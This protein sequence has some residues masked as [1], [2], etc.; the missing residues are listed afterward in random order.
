MSTNNSSLQERLAETRATAEA[1][2]VVKLLSE[3]VIELSTKRFTRSRPDRV[4]RWLQLERVAGEQVAGLSALAKTASKRTARVVG[5]GP[6]PRVEKGDLPSTNSI[7]EAP[8]VTMPI[9]GGV[10]RG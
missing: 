4:Q 6:A 7:I 1:T 8:P 9:N 5:A 10:E 2:M 3:A